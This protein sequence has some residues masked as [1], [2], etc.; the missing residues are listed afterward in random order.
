MWKLRFIG[1]LKIIRYFVK[2]IFGLWFFN[3]KIISVGRGPLKGLNWKCSSNQQF[4]MPLGIYE[5]ETANWLLASLHEGCVF[6]DI[7]ANFGY[8][9]LMG[10]KA[11]GTKGKVISFEPIPANYSYVKE[12]ISLNAFDNVVCEKVAISDMNGTVEF[13][14]E[15]NNANSHLASIKLKHASSQILE[16][17]LVQTISLDDFCE[18]NVVPDVV[19]CDVEGAEVLVLSGAKTLL[20][21]KKTKWIIS[22][23]SQELKVEC[24][25]IMQDAGY[26]VDELDGF[27]HELLCIPS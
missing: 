5:Q 16:R 18:K 15:K 9:T 23:H 20:E 1:K 22:C 11:V 25:K 27:H 24:R 3:G 2:W 26:S 7:G 10:A 17:V 14:V 21:K 13:A 19:K 4:W 12:L 6:F 8:F